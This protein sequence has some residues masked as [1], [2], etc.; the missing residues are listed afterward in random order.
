M[1]IIYDLA[2]QTYSDIE[3]AKMSES[4][5]RIEIGLQDGTKILFKAQ[6]RFDGDSYQDLRCRSG[7]SYGGV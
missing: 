2:N 1:P 6:V 5:N 4:M 3:Y 7:R